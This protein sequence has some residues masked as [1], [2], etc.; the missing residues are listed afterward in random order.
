M[1]LCQIGG[2]EHTPVTIIKCGQEL[3]GKL[4]GRKEPPAER[5]NLLTKTFPILQGG[6][7]VLALQDSAL[8]PH[9]SELI[10]PLCFA[11][12]SNVKRPLTPLVLGFELSTSDTVCSTEPLQQSH[13]V[14]YFPFIDKETETQRLM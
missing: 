3:K 6:R 12:L 5:S 11:V 10:A 2:K 9:R 4:Q 8:T 14:N 1:L 13:W 7:R